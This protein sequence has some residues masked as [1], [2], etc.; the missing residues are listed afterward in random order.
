MAIMSAMAKFR[1]WS[2]SL[3]ASAELGSWGSENASNGISGDHVGDGT[4]VRRGGGA[5]GDRGIRWSVAAACRI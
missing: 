2:G 1:D 5:V 3:A 4:I